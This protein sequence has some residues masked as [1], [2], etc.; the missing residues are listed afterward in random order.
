MV[1]GSIPDQRGTVLVRLHARWARNPT[2]INQ[3]AT[4][5]Q[6]KTWKLYASPDARKNKNRWWVWFPTPS[7][8]NQLRSEW[9]FKRHENY[10]VTSYVR[11]KEGKK[12]YKPHDVGQC[13]ELGWSLHRPLHCDSAPGVPLPTTFKKKD[14]RAQNEFIGISQMHISIYILLSKCDLHCNEEQDWCTCTSELFCT[15]SRLL[16]T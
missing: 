11:R 12:A 14:I 10:C 6:T 2:P 16:W 9:C 8:S 5:K 15:F 3:I 7:S 1:E 13:R 4:T